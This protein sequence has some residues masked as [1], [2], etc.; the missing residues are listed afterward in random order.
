MKKTVLIISGIVLLLVLV[1]AVWAYFFIFGAPES[2]RGMFTSFG[3]SN[4]TPFERVGGMN[5]DEVTGEPVAASTVLRQLA[6]KP[7]A[8]MIFLDESAARYVEQGTG[9]IFDVA[10][11]GGAEIQVSNTTF[12]RVRDA[13]FSPDASKVVLTYEDGGFRR[14]VLGTIENGGLVTVTLVSGA[15]DFSFS[16]NGETLHYIVETGNGTE[17]YEFDIADRT[18]AMVFR[19]PFGSVRGHLGERY[20]LYTKPAA[21]LLGYAYDI[22]GGRISPVTNGRF[23]LMATPFEEGVI[24]TEVSSSGELVSTAFREGSSIP[25]AVTVF[26]EKCAISSNT[27]GDL[28][29]GAT[30]QSP[31]STLPDDWYKGAVSMSDLFWSVDIDSEEAVLIADP[32]GETGRVLDTEKIIA[33]DDG[34]QFL[35]MNKTNSTLWL[36]T[37]LE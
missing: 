32:V 9:H 6:T 25:V 1:S 16:S 17:V 14:H 21:S 34:T 13:I 2:V 11:E 12:S 7:I 23:G 27:L 15:R 30:L 22:S 36:L 5:I 37:P 19:A 28:V 31:Q 26:P 24:V 3:N 29:C 18:S 4:E 10:L 8:G 35:I 33:S 20:Y